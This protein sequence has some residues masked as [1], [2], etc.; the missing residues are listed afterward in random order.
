MAKRRMINKLGDGKN[1]LGEAIVKKLYIMGKNQTWLAQ[2]CGCSK[3]YVSEVVHGKSK[4]SPAMT[5][6][7]AEALGMN[8]TEV[9]KLAL[10]EVA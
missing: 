4:P 9:R 1:K 10:E 7:I 6:K 5:E 3:Q 8:V 2:W